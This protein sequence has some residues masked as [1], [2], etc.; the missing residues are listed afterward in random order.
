VSDTQTFEAGGQR[1]RIT[2]KLNAIQQLHV[3][4]RL[5]PLVSAFVGVDTQALIPEQQERDPERAAAAMHALLGPLADGVAK[6][7][8]ADTEYILGA[9]MSVVQRDIGGGT[10]WA[11]MWNLQAKAMQYQDLTFIDLLTVCGRVLMMNLGDFGS[12]LSRT[13]GSPAAVRL[14]S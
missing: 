11:P 3:V 7:S 12:A 6:L 10:G 5:S 14:Q 4:R 9:C 1:Y 2:G 8:D 13:G